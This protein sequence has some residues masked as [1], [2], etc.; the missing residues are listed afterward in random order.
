MQPGPAP[1]LLASRFS[2]LLV[3]VSWVLQDT[4]TFLFQL[5]CFPLV[6]SKSFYLHIPHVHFQGVMEE[7]ELSGQM[8][9]YLPVTSVPQQINDLG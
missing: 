8:K 6:F 2:M 5:W 9:Q 4:I 7:R 1:G 3:H